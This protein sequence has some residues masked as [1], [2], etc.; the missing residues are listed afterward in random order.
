MAVHQLAGVFLDGAFGGD[1]Q[2]DDA[3][4]HRR[5]QGKTPIRSLAMAL[6]EV[7]RRVRSFMGRRAAGSFAAARAI[8]PA[9]ED[10]QDDQAEGRQEQD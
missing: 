10:D 4:D 6:A 5:D 9:V 1:A 7:K 3:A 8:V 2:P